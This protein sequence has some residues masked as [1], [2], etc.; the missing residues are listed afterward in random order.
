MGLKL[1][2]CFFL[3]LR[4]AFAGSM[5]DRPLTVKDYNY[6][7]VKLNQDFASLFQ[8]FGIVLTL[9]YEWMLNTVRDRWSNL[10]L[11]AL[12]VLGTAITAAIR[13]DLRRQ[14]A[15]NKG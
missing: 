5:P 15:Q 4:F 6:Q 14:A 8:I 2:Y 9:L 3:K 1:D 7:D 10:T 13:S 11:C 12:L